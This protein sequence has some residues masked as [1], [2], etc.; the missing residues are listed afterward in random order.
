LSFSWF[1]SGFV[2][3]SSQKFYFA[4]VVAIAD[5]HANVLLSS[6]QF[7]Y[8]SVLCVC[9]CCFVYLLSPSMF[10]ATVV[11]ALDTAFQCSCACRLCCHWYCVTQRINCLY[12]SPL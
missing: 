2:A 10:S 3:F 4:W 8:I 11:T 12:S 5:L 6:W 7:V 1:L 9:L